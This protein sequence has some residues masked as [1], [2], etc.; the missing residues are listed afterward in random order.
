MEGK[1][2]V[3]AGGGH[4]MTQTLIPDKCPSCGYAGFPGTGWSMSCGYMGINGF[5]MLERCHRC[6]KDYSPHITMREETTQEALLRGIRIGLGAAISPGCVTGHAC[7]CCTRTAALKAED[8][9]P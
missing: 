3:G 2:E 1:E 8:L 5:K 4:G 6:N 7:A 9:V